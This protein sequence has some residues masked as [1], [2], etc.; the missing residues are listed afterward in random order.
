[1]PVLEFHPPV[2]DADHRAHVTGLGVLDD[3]ADFHRPLRGTGLSVRV[4]GED[5]GSIAISH[6]EIV[7]SHVCC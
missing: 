6:R 7:G 3:H 5:V 2:L 4:V 1:V